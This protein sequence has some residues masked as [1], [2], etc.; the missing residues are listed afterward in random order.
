M[1]SEKN[2]N[3]DN[4]PN[5]VKLKYVKLGYHYLV[6]NAMYIF[7]VPLTIASTH[8]SVKDFVHLFNYLKLNPVI[9][10]MR[11][12]YSFTCNPSLHASS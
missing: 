2:E 12:T 10:T 8:L 11:C 5:S 7:L 4:E 6:S 3:L 1:E 9:Y